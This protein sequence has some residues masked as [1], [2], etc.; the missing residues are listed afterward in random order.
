VFHAKRRRKR[1]LLEPP[2]VS[3]SVNVPLYLYLRL[4]IIGLAWPD[5]HPHKHICRYIDWETTASRILI[6]RTK[7]SFCTGSIQNSSASLSLSWLLGGLD[8]DLYKSVGRRHFDQHMNE[9]RSQ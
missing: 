6:W 7:S 4:F 1:A 2:V 9:L 3:V 5:A 8:V